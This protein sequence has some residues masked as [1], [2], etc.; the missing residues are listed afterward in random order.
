MCKAKALDTYKTSFQEDLE[1]KEQDWGELF[2]PGF[3]ELGSRDVSYGW[4]II[5]AWSYAKRQ[6]S[7]RSHE[8]YASSGN[9]YVQWTDIYETNSKSCR[10]VWYFHGV[11]ASRPDNLFVESLSIYDYEKADKSVRT[12]DLFSLLLQLSTQDEISAI[13][14][15][16]RTRGSRNIVLRQKAA[17]INFSSVH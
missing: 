1:G 11:Q 3:C 14:S 8:K 10:F 9:V 12:N 15:Y 17:H 5:D 13:D 7:P 6:R 16:K 2:N 4:Y